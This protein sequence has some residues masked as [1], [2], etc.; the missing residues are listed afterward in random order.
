[1]NLRRIAALSMPRKFQSQPLSL[2]PHKTDILAIWM[3]ESDDEANGDYGARLWRLFQTHR[4]ASLWYGAREAGEKLRAWA[5][6]DLY[7][8]RS[9]PGGAHPDPREPA[10]FSNRAVLSKAAELLSARIWLIPEA[11]DVPDIPIQGA[12]AQPHNQQPPHYQSPQLAWLMTYPDRRPP[13]IATRATTQHTLQ[14]FAIACTLGYLTRGRERLMDPDAPTGM[15]VIPHDPGVIT[16]L[17]QFAIALLALPRD[18]PADWT[19]DCNSIRARY[20]AAPPDHDQP[21]DMLSLSSLSELRRAIQE[22]QQRQNNQ[23]QK[24]HTGRTHPPKSDRITSGP[25]T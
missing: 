1:M 13:D 10:A 15:T 23:Q 18:C 2:Q 5:L 17:H 22:G 3:A 24:K 4:F 14:E 16:I 12:Q 7:G 20:N 11:P 25:L 6:A 19:C 8:S 21:T 9:L